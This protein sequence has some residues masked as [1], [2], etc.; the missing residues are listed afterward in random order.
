LG[1]SG[2]AWEAFTCLWRG[3]AQTLDALCSRLAMRGH[4]CS[5]YA[6]A[7][8]DLVAHGWAVTTDDRGPAYGE[9]GYQL[10][11]VGRTVRE[12]AERA[13]DQC[14]FAPWACLKAREAGELAVLLGGLRDGLR[15]KPVAQTE[16]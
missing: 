2:A 1:V 16:M 6:A 15:G 8:A 3:E 5:D 12:D 9:K 11:D 10:T 4:A 7:L 14:F 13:I